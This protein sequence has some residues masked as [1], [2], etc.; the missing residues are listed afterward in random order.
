ME[1]FDNLPLEI[2]PNGSS[3]S[4]LKNPTA[5][6][7]AKVS[8]GFQPHLPTPDLAEVLQWTKEFGDWS[9]VRWVQEISHLR[10]YRNGQPENNES[11]IHRGV[12]LEVMVNG[13]IGYAGTS[14][15][16]RAGIERAAKFAE[17]AA[18]AASS[19]EPL[20]RFDLSI[21]P[22]QTGSYRSPS[23]QGLDTA[24][25]Q[26]FNA[27]L[28][29]CTRRLKVHEAITTAA[30]SASLIETQN[31]YLSRSGAD[32]RQNFV[33]IQDNYFVVAQNGPI[34]VKR[35]LHGP[36]ARCRQFGME[37]F[38]WEEVFA[39]CELVGRQAMELLAAEECPDAEM[40][41]LLHPDQ[42]YLQIHESIG[43]PLELDRILGDERNY[44]GWSFVQA[45]DFGQLRY[46]S[47]LLQ[48]TFDPTV[49]GEFASYNFDDAG[50]PAQREYLIRDGILLRGLGSLE[51]QKRLQVPGVA[52][53][54]TAGWNRAPIDRMANINVEPGNQSLAQ[55]IASTERG[56]FM[57]ANRSWS[58]DDYRN[59]FQ[60]GC[61]YARLI[62]DGRLTR[63]VRN[64]NYRG[65]TI[66]FWN[67]LIGVG[68]RDEFAS[69][70]SP[71]CGKGEPS[72]VIRVGH[73]SPPCLFK[74]VRVFGGGK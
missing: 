16:S 44:A 61:E 74:G 59:K 66:P 7:G 51:S 63:V 19:R 35:S 12:L 56:I 41:L 48:V 69:F 36:S 34:S 11:H 27:R 45:S 24:L 50:N 62:E 13:Q 29:E 58:I 60:F 68:N 25:L 72:Q 46:G 18:R 39:D 31:W 57:E 52:N 9:A 4:P 43:H 53:F 70:G 47:P 38:V 33:L 3:K 73:A 30:A 15:F 23:K 64:P 65:S 32:L 49:S 67:S 55:M 26:E 37:S 42:M 22:A 71:Y 20:Y 17:S 21:R 8:L 2:T 5:P 6:S 14:D 28:S 1:T 54:R 40:D 10:A